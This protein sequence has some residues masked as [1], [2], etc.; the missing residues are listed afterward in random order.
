ML[1]RWV[2]GPGPCRVLA[3][4]AR[5]QDTL[6]RVR[7]REGWRGRM[8]PFAQRCFSRRPAPWVALSLSN[9]YPISRGRRRAFCA[10]LP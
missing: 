3:G 1:R 6:A 8:R 9:L 7:A 5:L 10:R 4:R 2:M